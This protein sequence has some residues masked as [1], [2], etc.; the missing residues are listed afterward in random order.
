MKKIHFVRLVCA[1]REVFD[2][3]R[4][5]GMECFKTVKLSVHEVTAR[6]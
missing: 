2:N 6:L 3:I 5:H 1:I 4:M